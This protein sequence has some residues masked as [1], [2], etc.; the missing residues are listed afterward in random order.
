MRNII[1]VCA[2]LCACILLPTTQ[3]RGF[4]DDSTD[5]ARPG[6][7][8]RTGCEDGQLIRDSDRVRFSC[9]GDE[10]YLDRISNVLYKNDVQISNQPVLDFKISRN[11]NV[12]YRT[13][14]G[15]YLYN[16]QGLMDS[17]ATGVLFYLV[18][19][20]GDVVYLNQSGQ[21]YKNGASLT[22]FSLPVS[23]TPDGL[24]AQ[25]SRRRRSALPHIAI[26]CNGKA[27]YLNISRDLYVDKDRI[28]SQT[29]KVKSFKINKQ[30]DV[31]FL[32][33]R[34]R[35]F[36]NETQL[37]DGRFSV[38]DYR[39]SPRGKIAFLTGSGVGNLYYD[40][41]RLNAGANPIISFQFNSNG[42]I[43]YVDSQNRLWKNGALTN[44]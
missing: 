23:Q 21:L 38:M 36:H 37:F 25:E 18:S 42:D 13:M 43:V 39:V 10:A 44:D 27:V 33:D 6:R 24:M 3:A 12:F 2:I 41:Q 9:T 26:T 16:E 19:S 11:G 22:D 17:G 1:L 14:T 35:L 29:Y 32:D 20:S 31:F 30:G 4:N 28:S 15:G 8:Q 7:L 34:D 40:D 5:S